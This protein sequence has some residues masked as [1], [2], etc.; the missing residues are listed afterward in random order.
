MRRNNLLAKLRAG[1]PAFGTFLAL[2]S[3]L[4]AEQ[5]AQVGFDWLVIER[6]HHAIGISQTQQLLQAISTTDTVPLVRVPS[7]DRV[8]IAAALDAG[9]YG[10]VV[11]MVNSREQAEEVVLA[12]RYPPVGARG[13]GG[14]RRTLY[15]G[16]DYVAN[17]NDEIALIV[18][19]EHV[20]AVRRCR[21]ILSVPGIDA[22]FLG[23]SDLSAS[24]GLEPVWDPQYPEFLDAVAEVQ[25]VGR[26]LG[27]PGGIHT[28]THNVASTVAAGFLFVAIGYDISF[29]SAGAH[30]AVEAARQASRG[31]S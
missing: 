2:G 15:G 14:A 28:T 12:G 22:W 5:L 9:A 30:Q 16:S 17:A 11:P 25:R 3:P 7:S 20:D 13:V 6:E 8:D 23:P 31:A 10:V 1:E 4:G 19:I 29:M 27:V 21:E 26:E 18:M 24:M